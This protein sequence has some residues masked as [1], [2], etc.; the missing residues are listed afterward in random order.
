MIVRNA[1]NYAL[2]D[3]A[4][5][6]TTPLNIRL[7]VVWRNRSLVLRHSVGVARIFANVVLPFV[8]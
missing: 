1:V 6:F 4:M 5:L 2:H 3:A 7:D 8:K